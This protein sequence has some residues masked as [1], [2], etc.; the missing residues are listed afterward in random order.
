MDQG[1]EKWIAITNQL[2][3]IEWEKLLNYAL[4]SQACTN[5]QI[6]KMA[7]LKIVVGGRKWF[8]RAKICKTYVNL[9]IIVWWVCSLLKVWQL[10]VEEGRQL[11]VLDF[12][13]RPRKLLS[14]LRLIL[15]YKRNFLVDY[16]FKMLRITP[17]QE[18]MK[19]SDYLKDTM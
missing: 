2:A 11:K 3:L 12:F 16:Q 9:E 15:K 1:T 19:N 6:K 7:Q 8:R 14:S 5:Y 10:I 17:E 4:L 13:Q 18:E